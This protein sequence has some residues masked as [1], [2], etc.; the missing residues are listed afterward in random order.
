MTYDQVAGALGLPLGTV[1]SR[2]SRGR[3][4]LRLLMEGKTTRLASLQV[5][6]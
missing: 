6:K 1:M 4:K 2:L 5:V 3:E